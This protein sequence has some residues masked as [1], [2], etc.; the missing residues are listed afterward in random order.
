MVFLDIQMPGI[1]GIEVSKAINPDIKIV[2][3]TAHQDY[4]I[5]AFKI[6]STDFILKPVDEKRF[7]ITLD[8][9]RQLWT[10]K[11]KDTLPIRVSGE[12][13][14]L[15]INDV[16]LIEKQ[17]G[18]KKV[19]IYTSKASYKTNLSLN[20]LEFKLGKF[21]FIRT[22]KSFLVNINKIERVLPWEN[23][24]YVVKLE[25]TSKEVFISRKYAPTV[26]TAINII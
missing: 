26:K 7:Q 19:A 3:V 1:S 8:R 9:L 11:M 18:L 5:E 6:G 14:I 16:I 2:F 24:S 12:T 15:D 4:A 23:K 25:G 10:T 13:I 20:S 22:H 21:G 17:K